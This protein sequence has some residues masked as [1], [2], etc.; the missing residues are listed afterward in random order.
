VAGASKLKVV[1]A[2]QAARHSRGRRS[3]SR[4]VARARACERSA[5]TPE[6]AQVLGRL[7]TKALFPFS[8]TG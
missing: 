1:R 2:A 8:L 6:Q 5:A 3:A 7:R 4:G